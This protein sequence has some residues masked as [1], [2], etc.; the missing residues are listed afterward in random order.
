MAC[1]LIKKETPTQL[2]S[3]KICEIL[4]KPML[5]CKLLRTTASAVIYIDD[6]EIKTENKRNLSAVQ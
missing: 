5:K 4:R 3:Y 2:F 6:E 1:N